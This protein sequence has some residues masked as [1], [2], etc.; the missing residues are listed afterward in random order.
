MTDPTPAPGQADTV[1]GG[2]ESTRGA[3]T[4]T[5]QAPQPQ[6]SL[7]GGGAQ[8]EA[9]PAQ[10]PDA[11]TE[12]A[13]DTPE[14][15]IPET[16]EFTL[17]D[18]MVADKAVVDEFTPVAKELGL[19]QAQAQR[20]ADIYARNIGRV[21]AQQAETAMKFIDQDV[22]AVK[23]DPQYGGE[24]LPENMGHAE[25][26]LKA[27]DPEGKFVKHLNERQFISMN[28]PELFRILIAAGKLIGEDQTPGGRASF[29]TKSPADVL[30]PSMGK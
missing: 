4:G 29:G 7:L 12:Q 14:E 5:P 3:A 28:D 25:N 30:Y 21:A 10:V 17:P 18:G 1:S 20:L 24:K 22:A 6:T 8:Q 13:N 15:G 27:V 23:T 11:G 2:Q 16:Y 19:T 9:E 26:L